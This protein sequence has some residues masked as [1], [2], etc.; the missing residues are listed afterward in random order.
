MI[1][2]KSVWRVVLSHRSVASG[3]HLHSRVSFVTWF[4]HFNAV[5]KTRKILVQSSIYD[6]FGNILTVWQERNTYV[7]GN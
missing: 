7:F 2:R 1:K 4:K 6:R 5:Q 3:C